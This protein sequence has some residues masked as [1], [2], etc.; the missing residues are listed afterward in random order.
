M[1]PLATV[2]TTL[3]LYGAGA[4]AAALAAA[5]LGRRIPGGIFALF[6]LLPVLFLWDGVMRARSPLGPDQAFL[7]LP[8]PRPP[9]PWR[10]AWLA[11]VAHQIV[12]WSAAVRR[13][14]VEGS[15]PLRNRWNG[16][17]TPLDGNGQSAP[18]SPITLAAMLLPPLAALSFQGALRFFLCLSGMWLWLTELAVS[19]RAAV[20]GAV[21]FG[22]SMAMT[23]WILFP[24]TG[25]IALWPGV[26]FLVERLA[27]PS[28]RGR[29]VAA[30]IA[31][32]TLWP[33]SGHLETVVS[34][35]AFAAVWL[36]ARALS[37]EGRRVA[38]ILPYA[39]GASLA[40]LGLSAF[41]TLAQALAIFAS[42]RHALTP[43]PFWTPAL[44][45]L[46][47]GPEWG[48]G[49]L[50]PLF[51]RLLGDKI[52]VPMQPGVAGAF[53]EMASGHFGI[54]A[55]ACL[56]LLFRPGGRRARAERAL[57]APL[58]FGLGTAVGLWPFAEIM[59]SVPGLKLM[60]PLRYFVW[61][62]LAGAA[63]AAFELDRLERDLEENRREIL[64]PIAA[65]GALLAVTY[66]V[67][68]F[69]ATPSVPPAALA[70]A[71]SAFV[72]P[73][74]SLAAGLVVFAATG[75][76]AARFRSFGFG[77]LILVAAG[78]L[79][80][81]GR[82][83]AAWYEVTGLYIET[84]LIRFL[85]SRP[86]PFRI[87]G[88]G[89]MFFPNFNLMAG[90][91]DV[92]THD[93]AERRD[94]VEF[95]DA[96]CGYDPAPY[97]KEIANLDAPAL[98]FLNVRY[99]VSFPARATPSPKWTPAYS[100]PDGTVFENA[101]VLSPV[102]APARVRA[103][104]APPSRE[105]LRGIDWARE[106]VIEDP[107]GA[108]GP[109]PSE[110]GRAEILDYAETA[111][112][113]T[114]RVRTS[115]ASSASGAILVASLVND[116]GWRAR[117]ETGRRLTIARADGPF[118]AVHVPAGEHRIRL[119]YAPPGFRAGALVSAGTLLAAVLVWALRRVQR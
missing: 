104:R 70:A 84:P 64:W 30:L 19:R 108:L 1:T 45:L 41:S 3:A 107:S 109:I 96:T 50:L 95:L 81:Q 29:A 97:F 26:L 115:G 102:T 74:A 46:P 117:D 20:F 31:A 101:A 9:G 28:R 100:G 13:T 91:D 49:A 93:P 79:F 4:A 71:R 114:F 116:G 23:A 76:R 27:D 65:I 73:A 15:L 111:D 57:G 38:A 60:F 47:H 118:L 43:A 61:F 58:L 7:T 105:T 5:W 39:A 72:L 37:G 67:W 68:R 8:A 66:G 2:V 90:I 17:G 12:P 87:A 52:E 24:M 54:L 86:P 42:N 103:V 94:Y 11:D 69:V 6:A 99:L 75:G 44:S 22:F 88:E 34:A 14:W 48:R 77:L 18:Y 80:A 92:R 36:A 25:A 40:A 62:A 53:P 78:E 21:A 33:L 85:Q 59:S 106:A 35:A 55:A 83:L 32:L 63:I 89:R 16:C 56:L 98:D 113:V 112:R 10:G 82:R 51:P 119:D 110:N